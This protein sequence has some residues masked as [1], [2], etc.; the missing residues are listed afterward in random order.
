MAQAASRNPRTTCWNCWAAAQHRSAR[1]E[2]HLE[3]RRARRCTRWTSAGCAASSPPRPRPPAG[4]RPWAAPPDGGI[5]AIASPPTRRWWSRWRWG[6]GRTDDPARGH[7]GRLRRHRHP[8]RL[9]S[10]MEGAVMMG[11][12]NAEQRD[13]VQGRPRAAEQLRYHEVLRMNAA[14]KRI[15]VAM[16]GGDY[17]AF[18]GRCWRTW[19]AADGAGAVQR[20]LRG[21]RAHPQPADRQPAQRVT[22]RVGCGA[23]AAASRG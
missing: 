4:A 20:H 2:R 17:D 16:I 11:I 21:H 15:E 7:R 6:P 3:L 18:A 5:A 19:R 10:Q 13:H 9:R 22:G 23:S 12:G 14:P 1:A 8:E